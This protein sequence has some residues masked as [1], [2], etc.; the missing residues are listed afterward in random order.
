MVAPRS[1]RFTDFLKGIS[2]CLVY[3][4]I[5]PISGVCIVYAL[6]AGFNPLELLGITGFCMFLVVLCVDIIT[7][8][9]KHNWYCNHCFP[10]LI[11]KNN[12]KKKKKY[13]TT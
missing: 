13:I 10:T 11:T 3:A 8:C 1:R 9:H 12:L 2:A 7:N 6:K 4:F 5:Q